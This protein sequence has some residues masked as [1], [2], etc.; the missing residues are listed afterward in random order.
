MFVLFFHKYCK[1]HNQAHGDK[2]VREMKSQGGA[3][4]A[5]T[6]TPNG[7]IT[8]HLSRT[9]RTH[10]DREFSVMVLCDA[11]GCGLPLSLDI[12][13]RALQLRVNGHDGAPVNATSLPVTLLVS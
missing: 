5:Y 12:V 1:Y 2:D 9:G 7:A 3:L 4:G 11:C 13:R 8:L 6:P 10:L